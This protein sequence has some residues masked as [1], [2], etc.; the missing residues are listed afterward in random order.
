MRADVAR[1][2]LGLR[3]PA[4]HAHAI[5]LLDIILQFFERDGPVPVDIHV[6]EIGHEVEVATG[7]DASHCRIGVAIE[8]LSS[9]VA[10]EADAAK[11]ANRANHR[12]TR[13]VMILLAQRCQQTSRRRHAAG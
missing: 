2:S 6:I 12:A 9:A 8:V 10:S 5:T 11:S 13:G 3:A 1:D 4:L 7:L